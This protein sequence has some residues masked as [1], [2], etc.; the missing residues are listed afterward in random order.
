MEI[1]A[2]RIGEI[3][4]PVASYLGVAHSGITS[5]C[6]SWSVAGTSATPSIAAGS[7]AQSSGQPLLIPW[8]CGFSGASTVRVVAPGE[9][10][11]SNHSYYECRHKR[12]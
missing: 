11:H 12:Y 4:T 8:T 10:G 5:F 9:R 6:G 2:E 7:G 3:D 1:L